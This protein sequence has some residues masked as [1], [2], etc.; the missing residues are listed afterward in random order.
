MVKCNH[1]ARP[2]FL[3]LWLIAHGAKETEAESHVH[4]TVE[5]LLVVMYLQVVEVV[6]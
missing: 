1:V 4:V 5:Q 6:E 3:T 2:T